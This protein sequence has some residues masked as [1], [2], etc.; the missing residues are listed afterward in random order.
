MVVADNTLEPEGLDSFSNHKRSF[1]VKVQTV[2]SNIVDI[3]GR[4]LGV[5]ARIGDDSACTIFVLMKF[6]NL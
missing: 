3:P 6:T 1:W 4:A 2:A 5:G